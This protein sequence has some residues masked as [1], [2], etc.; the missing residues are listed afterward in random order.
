MSLPN[1]KTL[2]CRY[3]DCFPMSWNFRKQ[4][5]SL[6]LNWIVHV[7]D[8]FLTVIQ[9]RKH[10]LISFG[11]IGIFNLMNQRLEH[12]CHKSQA[13]KLC[14]L[15]WGQNFGNLLFPA[16]M[17]RED[18]EGYGGER[19]PYCLINNPFITQI[20][21]NK[22]IKFW[23][24]LATIL[25]AAAVRSLGTVWGYWIQFIDW[26]PCQLMFPCQPQPVEMI[27]CWNPQRYLLQHSLLCHL[28]MR[29]ISGSGH[30]L[31]L[32]FETLT[33][34]SLKGIP[35]LRKMGMQVGFPENGSSPMLILLVL[36]Q[37][38]D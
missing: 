18:S 25:L 5:S 35:I 27:N 7:M 38:R 3:W 33:P 9:M 12:N 14:A 24:K 2:F 26:P 8:Q 22:Y 17:P 32:P 20:W 36:W 11:L 1:S 30:T 34:R 4:L 29:V 37:E 16:P 23:N 10:N 21:S 15:T 28:R 13:L 31:G 6:A 19:Y